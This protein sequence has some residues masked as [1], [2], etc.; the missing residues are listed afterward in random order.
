MSGSSIHIHITHDQQAMVDAAQAAFPNADLFIGFAGP[1]IDDTGDDGSEPQGTIQILVLHPD[2][3]GPNYH[4]VVEP[5][6]ET[7]RLLIG[8]RES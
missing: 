3:V 6:G 4:L 8:G 2:D 5:S 7:Q 1:D